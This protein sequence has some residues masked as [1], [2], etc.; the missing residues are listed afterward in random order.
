M[1]TAM[2]ENTTEAT[3]YQAYEHASQL[4]FIGTTDL[5]VLASSTTSMSGTSHKL[6]DLNEITNVL[7]R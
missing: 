5:K 2:E 6:H 7:H 1:L 3:M 4:V